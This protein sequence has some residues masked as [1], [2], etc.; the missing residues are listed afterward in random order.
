MQPETRPS[1][2]VPEELTGQGRA[3]LTH[4]LEVRAEVLATGLG[5][6]LRVGGKRCR[7]VSDLDLIEERVSSAWCRTVRVQKWLGA[8]HLKGKPTGRGDATRSATGREGVRQ[9]AGHLQR[10]SARVAGGRQEGLAAAGRSLVE[11]EFG[12]GERATN[13][14]S[15]L[16]G[17]P[18]GPDPCDSRPEAR[19]SDELLC[20]QPG[21]LP[22][23]ACLLG[24]QHECRLLR[25][26][27]PTS[28]LRPSARLDGR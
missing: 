8:H 16:A 27:L 4:V 22:G 6:L 24:R 10:S 15:A 12:S 20:C 23:R 13:G 7:G 21:S 2:G 18:G 5:G 14:D 3:D 17:Q 25:Q 26:Q 9:D 28:S 11:V 1:V 19:A